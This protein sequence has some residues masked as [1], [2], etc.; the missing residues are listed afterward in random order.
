MGDIHTSSGNSGLVSGTY[1]PYARNVDPDLVL[2]TTPRTA[3]LNS[4]NGLNAN[5]TW[6]LFVSDNSAADESTLQGWGLTI[7]SVPEPSR[8]LLLMLGLGCTALRRRRMVK[9]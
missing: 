5:G 8:A 2:D 3:F 1:Q 7:N 4:F 9:A 6:T